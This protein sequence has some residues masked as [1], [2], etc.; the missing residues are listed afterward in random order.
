MNLVPL[1][2]RFLVDFGNISFH[3]C[4]NHDYYL[5]SISL[6]SLVAFAIEHEGGV[7]INNKIAHDYPRC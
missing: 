1:W 3:N 6:S 5:V 7:C 2:K 4:P